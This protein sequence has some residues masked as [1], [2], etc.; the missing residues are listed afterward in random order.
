MT[1]QEKA[2]DRRLIKNYRWTLAM[3]N[4]LGDYQ[5]W[6]CAGCGREFTS[7][8]NVDHQHF[9]VLAARGPEF[10][11]DGFERG[12]VAT[13]DE[14]G[15]SAWGATR[16]AATALARE[17]ALPLSVRGLL[18]AGRHCRAGQGC[19][20]RLLGRV[21][22]IP[23]LKSMIRYLEDPPARKILQERNGIIV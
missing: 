22:N 6:K 15:V 9:K 8:P 14:F 1:P 11:I 10:S 12:W 7:P 17:R 21:D 18:C 19:C 16:T 2:K 4:A 23:W 20:N 3:F 5:D 13:V